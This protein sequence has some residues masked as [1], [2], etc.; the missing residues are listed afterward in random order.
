MEFQQELTALLEGKTN[1]IG[2]KVLWLEETDSTNLVCRRMAARGAREGLAVLA[3]A[4]TAGRGRRG[5]SFQSTGDLGLYLSV[6]LRPEQGM[7][8]VSNMTAWVAVAV[9]DGVERACGV[10]PEIKWINDIILNGKKLGGILTE[11]GL[12]QG[13]MDHL[14]VGIGVNVNHTPEDFL[15]ELRSMATSLSIELPKAPDMADLAAHII[16]A[17]DEM[18]AAFPERKAEYLEKYRAGCITTGKAVQLITPA[19]REEA[20]S[21][22][23]DDQFRLVVRMETGEVRALSAG[24]VS[25]RGMYGYL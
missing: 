25:V 2:K 9:C 13:K 7:E 24:E 5:R 6:L 11:A 15:P 4:Q 12:E 10:R 18:Y 16:R 17:L 23:I 21:L 8:E 19:S 1:C 14:V 22:S 3:R 20:E